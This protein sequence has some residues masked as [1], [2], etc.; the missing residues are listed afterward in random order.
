MLVALI[1]V[2]FAAGAVGAAL[3]GDMSA[4]Q[5]YQSLRKPWFSPPGWVFGPVWSLLYL[6][7][8]V[9]AWLTWRHGRATVAMSLFAIQLALNAAWTGVFFGLHLPGLA[10]AELML[11]WVAVVATVVAFAARSRWA[12][13]LMLPYLTWISFAAVLNFAIWQLN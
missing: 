6:S 5:W 4:D 10:F 9:A 12:G 8:G 13:R 1:A 11:L 2:S 7:M 3:G